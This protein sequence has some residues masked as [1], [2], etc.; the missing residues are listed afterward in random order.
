MN[1]SK[2]AHLADLRSDIAQ[3]AAS[4]NAERQKTLRAL[5]S[6]WNRK[7]SFLPFAPLLEDGTDRDVQ[8][9]VADAFAYAKDEQVLVPLMQAA[10][11]PVNHNYSSTLIW[12][13]GKYDCTKHL[14]FFVDF[15]LRCADP[16]EAMWACVDVIEA[17]RGPF[18]PTYLKHTV[19]RL[20]TEENPATEADMRVQHEVFRV[21]AASALLDRYYVQVHKQWDEIETPAAGS[22][23]PAP[24]G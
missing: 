8:Y 4:G 22:E 17:M 2:K 1:L 7:E 23:T 5:L 24:V 14:A 10:V 15:M 6:C 20:L 11:A 16:G 19:H 21:Q 9:F 18:E 13:C 3:A 12:P